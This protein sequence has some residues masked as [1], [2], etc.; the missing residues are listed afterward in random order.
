MSLKSFWSSRG[1]YVI[2]ATK[3]VA[4]VTGVA[5]GAVAV[6]LGPITYLHWHKEMPFRMYLLG[7]AMALG[8]TIFVAILAGFMT[9]RRFWLQTSVPYDKVVD[10]FNRFRP[11]PRCGGEIGQKLFAG[12]TLPMV[13]DP[14]CC[15]C[16]TRYSLRPRFFGDDEFDTVIPS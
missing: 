13:A 2:R 8:L 9:A 3:S 1:H 16:G 10:D 14:A 12:W 11:C 4:L 5:L 6:F 15:A 7:L